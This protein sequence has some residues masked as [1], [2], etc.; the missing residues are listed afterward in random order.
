MPKTI[1]TYICHL[2]RAQQSIQ[3]HIV[4]FGGNPV[5][6]CPIEWPTCRHCGKRMTFLAQIPLLQPIRI[7]SKYAMAYIFMCPGNFDKNGWLECETWLPFSGANEV[8]LQEYSPSA[9][10]IDSVCEY[11]DYVVDFEHV[12]ESPVDTSDCSV[13]EQDR[14]TVSEFSKIGGVPFWL[15][16]NE[17]PACQKCKRPMKFVAQF[18]AELDG[19]LPAD[20]RKW[21]DEKYKFFHFGGDD[22]IG[23]LFICKNECGAAFLWQCT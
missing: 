8:I 11:P 5:L 2:T 17:T 12:L 9:I 18:A 16:A 15:Q 14:L 6:M 21:D 3:S 20:P 7:S 22:G 1:D 13:D 19:N 23:Y 4:K 10:L